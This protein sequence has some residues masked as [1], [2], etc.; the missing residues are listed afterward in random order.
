MKPNGKYAD[1]RENYKVPPI[2]TADLHDDPIK[3]FEAWFDYASHAEVFEPNA[4]LLSTFGLDG[5]PSSRVVLLKDIED[6][7]FVFFTNYSS[8]KGR[9]LAKNDKAALNFVWLNLHRQIRIKG[10]VTK[11][12]EQLSEN[13]FNTRPEGSRIGAIASPQSEVLRDRKHLEEL[14]TEASKGELKR[15]EDWGGYVLKPISFEFWQGQENRLHDRIQYS[16][17]NG[18]WIKA[19][20]AP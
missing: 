5:F 13:Y 6:G 2:R 3:Q 18:A 11:I 10:T 15:P 4:M 14:F 17:K 16:L 9:E 7:G 20:L 19:R 12:D 8:L 1:L